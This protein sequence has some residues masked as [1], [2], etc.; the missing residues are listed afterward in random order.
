MCIRVPPLPG[1]LSIIV[2]VSGQDD[3]LQLRS[4]QNHPGQ[5]GIDQDRTGQ[6][7]AA[8]VGMGEIGVA[9][10]GANHISPNDNGKICRLGKKLRDGRLSDRRRSA[11]FSLFAFGPDIA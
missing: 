5:L 2:Y 7:G 6:V 9:E 1:A 8:E 3:A 10:V 4:V 11:C